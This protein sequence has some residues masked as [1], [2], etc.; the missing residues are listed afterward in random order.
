MN[1]R[2][3]PLPDMSGKEAKGASFSLVDVA[4]LA[5]FLFHVQFMFTVTK[6]L[7]AA[8]GTL[9][10]MISAG[11]GVLFSVVVSFLLAAAT[12]LI[13]S[14]LFPGSAGNQLLRELNQQNANRGDWIS[15]LYIGLAIG[16]DA[17]LVWSY[18]W[19]K[20]PNADSITVLM[21]TMLIMGLFVLVP[22]YFWSRTLPPDWLQRVMLAYNVNVTKVSMMITMRET[23][24][25]M[26]RFYMALNAR[27]ASSAASTNPELADEL[28]E[29]QNKLADAVV[30]AATGMKANEDTLRE[31]GLPDQATRLHQVRGLLASG[32]RESADIYEGRT[33]ER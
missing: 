27:M 9:A 2:H 28:V 20:L 29:F 6:P 11:V 4:V 8:D 5:S 10:G 21:L 33:N 32:F 15:A 17:W 7:N 1:L 25:R 26:A 12:P 19:A 31:M 22:S 14:D 3:A 24:A 18:W 16:G 13:L 30:F 23:D